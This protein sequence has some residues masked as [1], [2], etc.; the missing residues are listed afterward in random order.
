ML[1]VDGRELATEKLEHTIPFLLPIDETF[2]V[3]VDTRTP[4]ESKLFDTV[5]F[6]RQDRQADFQAW[7]VAT[8]R[9]GPGQ[10]DQ[11]AE[12]RTTSE[13]SRRLGGAVACDAASM[14]PRI[15]DRRL[16]LN[17]RRSATQAN[18]TVCVSGKGHLP[19]SRQSP[20]RAPPFP[21]WAG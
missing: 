14:D 9:R 20:K 8:H 4:V 19:T 5:P 12:R 10:A 6:Q 15:E 2:D 13:G 3:G 18:R 7:T 21:H 16:P 17:L 1:K 11:R